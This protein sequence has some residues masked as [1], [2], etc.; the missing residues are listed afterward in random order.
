[1]KRSE[2][3]ATVK[4]REDW[5]SEYSCLSIKT[6]EETGEPTEEY[7]SSSGCDICPHGLAGSVYDAVYL[8]N[9]D[10]KRKVFDNILEGQICGDC[11]CSI[12]NGDYTGLEFSVDDEDC[13]FRL[14]G[15]DMLGNDR[16]GYEFNDYT[17]S[18]DIDADQDIL[19]LTDKDLITW[20]K[21]NGHLNKRCRS[22]TVEEIGHQ[23]LNILYRG[24]PIFE[25]SRSDVKPAKRRA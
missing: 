6:D 23:T 25:I 4:A 1:M 15:L 12:I 3:K 13:S 14:R 19:D 2:F 22:F 20:L 17:W 7:F 8:S 9:A 10:I 21:A 18:E 24:K 11:L 16:E 5:S